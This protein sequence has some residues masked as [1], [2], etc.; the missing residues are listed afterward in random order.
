MGTQRLNGSIFEKMFRS[1]LMTLRAHEEEVNQMNVFPVADGDT[2]TNM[3]LTLE[4][5]LDA[6]VPRLESGAYLKTFSDGMLFGARGNSGVILSQLFRGF[7]T[8]L[9]HCGN[10]NVGELRNAFIRGYRVAYEAVVSPV[11]GTILTVAREG[12]EHIRDHVNRGTTVEALLAM[13][14]AEMRKSLAA[15]PQMLSVLREAGVVDSGAYGYILIIEGML[16]FLRGEIVPTAE[17]KALPAVPAA[18]VVPDESVFGEDSAFTEGYCEEFILQLMKG[19][20]YAQKFRLPDF[21]ADLSVLGTSIVAAQDGRRV[22]VHIHTFNPARVTALAQKYGVF[23]T[24]KLENMQLQHNEVLRKRAEAEV[25][26]PKKL[27][28]VAAV[29]GEGLE[30]LFTELGCD[31]VVRC[32]GKMNASAQDFADAI[33]GLR[34]ERIVILPNNKNMILAAEQAVKLTGAENVT[35]LP[36]CS[37]ADGYFALAMD[38]PDSDDADYRV[39]QMRE[40]I[41]SV[42]TVSE[43]TATKDYTAGNGGVHCR[44][45][46]NIALVGD[47]VVV[48]STDWCDCVVSGLAAVPDLAERETAL[49]LRGEGVPPEYEALLA[50]RLAAAFPALEVQ[51]LDGGQSVYHWVIGVM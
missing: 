19:E 8:E 7:F 45:G 3:A 47:R 17:K 6:A 37:F 31:A 28:T 35:V 5:G 14:I 38:V 1:G 15:T 49:V 18:A 39:A 34:A 36:S 33:S 2:G 40:G 25:R 44:A 10:V 42:V 32:P 11:E 13:Y 30:K 4:H 43:T 51:L 29:S 26:P 22:K 27:A 20:K 9:A 23:L 41:A 46:E 48:A 50:D 24:F 12:I 16:A 21:T